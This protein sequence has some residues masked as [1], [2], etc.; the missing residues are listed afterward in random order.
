MRVDND[1]RDRIRELND[2]FRKTFDL[3]KGLPVLTVGVASLSRDM[4]AM[5]IRKV[6]NFDA[7][8]ERQRPVWRTRLRRL[9]SWWTAVHLE[10]RLLRPCARRRI[11]RPRRRSADETRPDADAGRG[12]LAMSV[13]RFVEIDGKRYLWRDVLR[14]RKEQR[15]AARITQPTLFPLTDDCRPPRRKQQAVASPSRACS[16]RSD[17]H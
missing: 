15:Q 11:G 8:T 10:N 6:S 5:A 17:A 16:R 4:Q 7:F 9:R 12:V 14:L 2:E 1:K 3:T 13:P